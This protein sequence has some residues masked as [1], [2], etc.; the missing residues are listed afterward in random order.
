M[1]GRKAARNMYSSNTNKIGIQ[2]ICWFY[3]Q[4]ICYDARSYDRSISYHLAY[5]QVL[6]F[7]SLHKPNIYACLY[8]LNFIFHIPVNLWNYYITQVRIS[9]KQKQDN[10]ILIVQIL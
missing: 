8:V 1:M 9:G 3:S 2:C 7:H 6:C 10:C 4:G 5:I